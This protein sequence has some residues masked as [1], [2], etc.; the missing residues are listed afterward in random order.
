MLPCKA[1]EL[2][3]YDLHWPSNFFAQSSFKIVRF[4]RRW[5]WTLTFSRAPQCNAIT[6]SMLQNI[7][8]KITGIIPPR[9]IQSNTIYLLFRNPLT[10]LLTLLTF[11]NIW[12]T[13]QT[14]YKCFKVPRRL[15]TG[16]LKFSCGYKGRGNSLP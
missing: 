9:T 1:K 14:W 12:S 6:P 7:V 13:I 3:W 11:R 16:F 10:T 5:R 2:N 8:I 15:P 4:L